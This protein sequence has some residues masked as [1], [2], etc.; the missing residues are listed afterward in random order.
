MHFTMLYF[1]QGH[2]ILAFVYET[3]F[4]GTS[5]SY[6]TLFN[7]RYVE[8]PIGGDCHR[9]IELV[10]QSLRK[11]FS[12]LQCRSPSE[13]EVAFFFFLNVRALV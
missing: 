11:A 7:S 5:A 9:P 2:F 4:D 12:I 13:C 6:F 1:C 8:F 10:A 3:S